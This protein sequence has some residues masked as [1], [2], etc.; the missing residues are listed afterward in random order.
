MAIDL[1]NP[2]SNPGNPPPA[3]YK[4]VGNYHTH[5]LPAG[6]EEPSQADMINS[7]LRGVPGIVVS[8]SSI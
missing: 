5:P 8:K 4:I 1:D 6:N 2:E 7:Y 3:G